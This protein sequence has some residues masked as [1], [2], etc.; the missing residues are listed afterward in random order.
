MLELSAP[1]G[2]ALLDRLADAGEA[3]CLRP[4]FIAALR[5]DH[6]APLVGLALRVAEARRRASEKLLRSEKLYFT[7]ELLEQASA[8]PPSLHRARRLAPAGKVL[9]LGCG[10][11]GDLMNL[12]G[13]GEAAGLERDPLALAMAKANL[14]ERGLRAELRQGEFPGTEL[15]AF[16]ALFADPARRGGGRRPG[17]SGRAGRSLRPDEFSPPPSAIRPLLDASKAWCVK[18]GPALDL[19]HDALSAPGALLEGM[20]REDY[21]LELV[22]WRG[23]LREAA[24]WGGDLP[25]ARA[26]ATVLE[27]DLE[28]FRVHRFEGDPDLPPPPLREPGDW[29]YEPDASLFRAGILAD[30]SIRNKLDLL[31]DRI[32]YLS[33]DHRVVSP[34]LRAYRRLESFPFSLARAQEALDRHGAGELILKKRGFP[35]APEDLRK[36]LKVGEGE[37]AVLVLHRDRRGHRAHL[38]RIG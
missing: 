20:R 36:R 26:A 6:S 15:P 9:D 18:W 8:H 34:F 38:C 10:A 33:S 24:I 37:P 21:E 14:A 25:R 16:D 11:G 3:E 35:Q 19:S 12:A 17:G 32:A 27:G 22:S 5:R 4:S 1:A 13:L 7:P 23:E 31:A 2:R 28:D 29:I 30:F